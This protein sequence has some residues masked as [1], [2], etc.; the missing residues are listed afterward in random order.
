MKKR[1]FLMAAAAGLLPT[2][3]AIAAAYP[4]KAI[5]L[6]VPAS[7]A[8]AA[9]FF[10]RIVGVPLGQALGQPI[11][12]DNRAGAS[13]TIGA[14]AVAKSP[15]DG[16][17]L[18]MAQSTSVAIA[19]HM[20][21]KLGYDTLKDFTP[22]TLVAIAPNILVVHPSVKANTVKEL[23]A[24]AK[25]KPDALNFGSAG[26]GAPSHLAGVMFRN[27]AGVEM[28]HI[29]YK[30]SG[31]AVNALLAGEVQVMFAPIVAVLQQIKAGRLKAIALTSATPSAAMP[32][33]P[34]IAQTGLPGYDISSWFGIFAPANTPQ[35]IID[36]LY[37]ETSKIVNTPEM[38][39]RFI[40]EGAEAVGNTPAKFAAFF[41]SE[42]TRFEKVV[43]DSGAVIE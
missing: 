8:G 31:P 19:P 20:Y 39:K 14:D 2:L 6:V 30:G 33:L 17:T 3:P 10:S 18:L 38:K 15:P 4:D 24:L 13:G 5:K 43:K 42:Y 11:V 16:Y 21:R 35:P 27:M 26:N 41:K 37:K 29:A 1:S 22:V 28:T 9:D 40:D 7:P 34:T 23:I 12:I 32:D 36:R 25:A